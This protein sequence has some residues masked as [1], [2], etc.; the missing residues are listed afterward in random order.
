M[1]HDP[2]QID[3]LL[4]PVDEP[5]PTVDERLGKLSIHLLNH[6]KTARLSIK[7]DASVDGAEQ[8][9]RHAEI[10]FG[11]LK[12]DE[13]LRMTLEFLLELSPFSENRISAAAIGRVREYIDSM[14]GNMESQI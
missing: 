7:L 10:P 5:Q 14:I 4:H 6:E 3:F 13:N 1:A 8:F 12:S 2:F 9:S 11:S